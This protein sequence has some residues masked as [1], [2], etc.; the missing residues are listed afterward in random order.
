[1]FAVRGYREFD[2]AETK[3]GYAVFNPAEYMV[4]RFKTLEEALDY[5]KNEFIS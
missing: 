1:M 5:I 2:I 3:D 4:H